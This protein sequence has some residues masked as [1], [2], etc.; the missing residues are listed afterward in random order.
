M[1]RIRRS[2]AIA[3][4]DYSVVES[5]ARITRVYLLLSTILGLIVR[6]LREGAAYWGLLAVWLGAVLVECYLQAAGEAPTLRRRFVLALYSAVGLVI[7]TSRGLRSRGLDLTN[8]LVEGGCAALGTFVLCSLSAWI[9][10]RILGLPSA[11]GQASRNPLECCHQC[12]YELAGNVSGICPEC[13]SIIAH[14]Y[15]KHRATDGHLN[16][17]SGRCDDCE[18]NVPKEYD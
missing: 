18:A 13:G 5:S 7:M 3:N 1:G 2:R 16:A 10:S 4:S 6:G 17:E 15:Y 11:S 12:G 8:G 9:C 14:I